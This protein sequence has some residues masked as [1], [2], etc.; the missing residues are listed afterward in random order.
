[1]VM[2]RICSQ[3]PERIRKEGREGG[4]EDSRMLTILIITTLSLFKSIL[5]IYLFLFFVYDCI[6]YICVS[7]V[8]HAVPV[9]DRRGRWISGTGITG[10]GQPPRES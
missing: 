8:V 9:E 4:K 7:T 3:A 6:A 5:K 10:S 2:V 1:M